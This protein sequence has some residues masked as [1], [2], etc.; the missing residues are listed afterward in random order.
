MLVTTP[1]RHRIG[2]N[3]SVTEPF[4]SERARLEAEHPIVRNAAGKGLACGLI[5][6]VVLGV[7]VFVAWSFSPFAPIGLA[8]SVA[9]ALPF[10]IG[11]G[12]LLLLVRAVRLRRRR[13]EE[14]DRATSATTTPTPPSV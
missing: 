12:V 3:E 7:I 1:R 10:V 13:P 4:D 9:Q 8:Y 11:L 14:S 6:L 2:Q 5:A